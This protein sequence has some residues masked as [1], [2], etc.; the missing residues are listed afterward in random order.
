MAVRELFTSGHV[1]TLA[2]NNALAFTNHVLAGLKFAF[3]V[4][5]HKLLVDIN[6]GLTLG[7]VANTHLTVL[8]SKNRRLLGSASLEKLG[9]PWQT[10]GNV[11]VFGPGTRQLRKY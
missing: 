3:A 1:L 5:A 9:Y 6:D 8:L 7:S 10:T 4:S 2:H 11:L